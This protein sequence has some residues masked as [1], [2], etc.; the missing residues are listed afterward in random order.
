M[1][2]YVHELPGRLRIRIPS[3]RKNPGDL[4][5]LQ[6]YVEDFSAV[7]STSVN[8]VTGSII[9][10]YDKNRISSRQIMRH[11]VHE[12][13]LDVTEGIISRKGMTQTVGDIGTAASRV[14]VGIAIERAFQGTPLA[15][16]AS[17][18]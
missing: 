2:Y 12:G 13:Y 14:L 3:L 1:S 11:L 4:I 16:L 15:L 9:I 8:E 7:N 10:N 17:L 6:N 5:K 18:I